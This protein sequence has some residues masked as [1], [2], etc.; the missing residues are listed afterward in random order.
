M[1]DKHCAMELQFHSSGRFFSVKLIVI[2]GS[3]AC[4]YEQAV[5]SEGKLS[6]DVIDE[7]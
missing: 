4:I 2:Y 6:I 5:S 1:L 3:F 7:R